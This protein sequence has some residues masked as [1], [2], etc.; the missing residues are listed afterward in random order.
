MDQALILVE[1]QTNRVEW[2]IVRHQKQQ[3]A[4]DQRG[5]YRPTAQY[6]GSGYILQFDDEL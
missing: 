6:M 5:S 2:E 1:L 3:T 4:C